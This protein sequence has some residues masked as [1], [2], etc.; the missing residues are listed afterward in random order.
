MN[1]KASI[2]VLSLIVLNILTSCSNEVNESQHEDL[3]KEYNDSSEENEKDDDDL[4]WLLDD[5][6]WEIED[7]IINIDSEE[8]GNDEVSKIKDESV[9]ELIIDERCIWC[10]KCAMIAPTNFAMDYDTLKAVVISQKNMLSQKV[11]TSAQVCPTGSIH[12]S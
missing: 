3:S 8:K 2:L 6:F 7:E 12:I 1:K 9:K 4:D 10:G 11:S 5:I